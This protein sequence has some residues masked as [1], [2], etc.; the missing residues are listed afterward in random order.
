MD[1]SK[2]D[3]HKIRR[4]RAPTYRTGPE[5]APEGKCLS[6]APLWWEVEPPPRI[7]LVLFP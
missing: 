1:V 5:T 2:R 4:H 6:G 3:L 7:L